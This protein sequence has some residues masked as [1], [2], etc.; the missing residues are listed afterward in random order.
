MTSTQLLM[1]MR[2]ARTPGLGP[3][4]ACLL[5]DQLGS[6]E[7]IFALPV[8]ELK[9]LG[10][11]PRIAA[12]LQR[13]ARAAQ[14]ELDQLAAAGF[15]VLGLGDDDYPQALASIH[16]PPQVLSCWGAL[17]PTDAQAVAIVG[18]RRASFQGR[19]FTRQLAG[20][21]TE[22]GFT[23]ISGLARGIDAAAH[24]GALEA[25]G[26]TLG[27][28]ASG[29]EAVYP[30]EH[31]GL[32]E[33]IA[34]SGAV[35]SEFPP[36]AAPRRHTFPQRNRIVAG[37]S[38]A[39]VVVE[40]GARSG[41]LITADFALQEGR[42]LLAMPGSLRDPLAQGSNALIKDGARLLESAQD[43]LDLLQGVSL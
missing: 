5:E 7:R 11:S 1:R 23:V 35:L 26:R 31:Q 17:L 24:R 20:E 9:R 29:L 40:A 3:R 8:P 4:G 39:V 32:T 28:L 18:A 30:P 37:L 19:A 33:R 14:E 16:D 43:V 15:S 2:L 41:A 22:A 21:L 36:L 27:V 10:V 6:L 38:R 25:G 13:G 34:A 42:E 12:A